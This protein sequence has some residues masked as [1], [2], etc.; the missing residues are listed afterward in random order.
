MR[1]DS[2]YSQYE[3][4]IGIVL[5]GSERILWELE[6]QMILKLHQHTLHIYGIGVHNTLVHSWCAEHLY[7]H[8]FMPH[9]AQ[10]FI[11][12]QHTLYITYCVHDI[13]RA[14]RHCP[15]T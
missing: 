3:R 10:L 8:V 2:Q 9:K 14:T 12:I 13:P 1:V 15:V 6:G 7:V 5:L 11:H 4:D